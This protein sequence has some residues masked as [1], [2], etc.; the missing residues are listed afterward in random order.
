MLEIDEGMSP[1][2]ETVNGK[3]ADITTAKMLSTE[4]IRN[5]VVDLAGSYS[6]GLGHFVEKYTSLPKYTIQ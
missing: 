2:I 4:I 1:G 6:S 3:R 5:T